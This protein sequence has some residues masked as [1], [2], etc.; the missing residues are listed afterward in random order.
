MNNRKSILNIQNIDLQAFL[1]QKDFGFSLTPG[2]PR[3]LSLLKPSQSTRALPRNSIQV[4]IQRLKDMKL[5]SL[6]EKDS[7]VLSNF[8]NIARS[9]ICI[10]EL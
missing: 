1:P 9:I 4:K 8:N 6:F 5:T 10:S 2:P 7:A 3:K